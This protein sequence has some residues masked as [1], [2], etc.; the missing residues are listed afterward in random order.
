MW[1]QLPQGFKQGRCLL[2]PVAGC[3]IYII[4]FLYF[5]LSFFYCCRSFVV[6][7]SLACRLG[8]VLP[9]V[10]LVQV[11]VCYCKYA[12][13]VCRLACHFACRF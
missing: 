13:F 11:I 6:R 10:R 2:L 9:V 12:I 8:V 7:M 5:L 4:F 3:T 1:V